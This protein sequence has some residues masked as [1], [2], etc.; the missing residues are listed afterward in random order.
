LTVPYNDK[1]FFD[2]GKIMMPDLRKEKP[3]SVHLVENFLLPHLS[4]VA[5]QREQRKGFFT[6]RGRF[7]APADGVYEF[8]VDSCGPVTLDIGKQVVVEEIGQYHQN[9]KVRRG[10]AAL[11]K[12]WHSVALTV[13]DPIFW[14]LNTDDP[15]P[16]KVSYRLDGGPEQEVKAGQLS[17]DPGGETLAVP[18][19]ISTHEPVSLL[20]EPGLEMAVYDRKNMKRNPD[21]LDIDAL[22]PF[23]KEKVMDITQNNNGN[24]VEVYNG[25]FLAPTTGIYTFNSPAR[26]YSSYDRN[27]VR[28]GD[29]VVV[30]R[31][32]PGRNP[33]RKVMLKAGYHPIS[34]RL[35]ESRPEFTVVYPGAPNEVRLTAAGLFRPARVAIAPV[36]CQDEQGLYEL[37]KPAEIAMAPPAAAVGAEQG[38]RRLRGEAEDHLSHRGRGVACLRGG[39]DGA[40]RGGEERRLYRGRWGLCARRFFFYF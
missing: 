15:M 16:L 13:C 11:A 18:P 9:Q 27:Q 12:G 35:G 25:Y 2:A 10:E 3:A 33:L 19:A 32:V 40:G 37:F 23:S 34:L 30:Q 26:T 14:K 17:C 7:N 22:S 24:V 28:I 8:A 1:G 31:G 20:V 36:G 38:G 29:E 6:F 5:P 4:P 39:A 21:Y